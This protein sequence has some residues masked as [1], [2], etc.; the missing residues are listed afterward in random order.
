MPN[1]VR[2]NTTLPGPKSDWDSDPAKTVLTNPEMYDAAADFNALRNACNDLR[3]WIQTG[4]TVGTSALA[5][6][7]VDADGR[8]TGVS[9]AA[10]GSIANAKLA[11]MAAGTIKGSIAGGTPADLTG[12]QVTTLLDVFTSTLKG[13]VPFSGGGTANFLRADG[14]WAAPAGGVPTARTITATSP[15]RIDGGASADLSADRTLSLATNGVTNSLLAQMATLTLKGNNTG[16]TANAAD[17]TAAQA[18]TL[19]AI[20]AGDVSGLAAI[21]TSGSAA[22]LS[23]GTIAAARMPALTGDVTSSAGSVATTIANNAVTNA[24]AA[25]MAAHTYKGNNTGSTANA[26]DLTQAQLTAELN[27]FTSALQGVVPLSGGGTANFLRADGS[28]VAPPTPTLFAGSGEFGSGI[29]GAAVFDGSTAVSGFTRS[30]SV[31]T[32]TRDAFFTDVTSGPGVTIDMTNGG[33]ITGFDIWCN[34]TWTVTSGTTTIKWNGNAA[35]SFTG[36]AGLATGP[37]GGA[38]GA[39]STGIQNAGQAG[40]GVTGAT[41]RFGAGAGGASGAS[42]TNANAAGGTVTIN[43]TDTVGAVETWHAVRQGKLGM[44]SA[45]SI[46]AGGGGGASGGG[47]TGIAKGGGGGG[48]GGTGVAGIRKLAATGTLAL[49][50]KGGAGGDGEVQTGSNAGGG[51]GGGGGWV[52]CGYGG[53]SQPGNLTLSAAGGA[54]GNKQGTGNN[55]SAGVN[56]ATRFFALGP[57]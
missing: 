11:N 55:G 9:A 15:I 34:G 47:T 12:T 40:G 16:S 48:G 38:S 5:T 14:T 4:L 1:F 41:N 2:D 8:I 26:A 24:K 57:A 33:T 22:D 28:W 19:L 17:L 36:G 56:G 45:N 42:A 46:M 29:D 50:A 49:E 31:Y 30:G 18:K 43:V 20:A 3:G 27:V 23:T 52:G 7:I 6:L 51:G 54:G 25:Q 44:A 35:S 39:G 13:L 10:N 37:K 53:S 21:A 32:A